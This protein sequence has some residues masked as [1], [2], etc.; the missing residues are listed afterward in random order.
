MPN[1]FNHIY[2]EISEGNLGFANALLNHL[3][4]KLPI[5]R[6]QRDLTDSTVLRN[7][8]VGFGHSLIAYQ[9]TVKGI[10]KLKVNEESLAKE[11]DG[12]WE[13]LAEPIQTVMRRFGIEKPYEKLKELTRG[14]RVNGES[15]RDFI[16]T[17]ELPDAAKAELCEL[18]PAKYIGRAV[19]FINELD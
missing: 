4:Q 8:G 10:S 15:M 6:W 5:S 1:K 18:T 13:V 11:L 17:L 19:E 9:A 14:K 16:M 2:F 3:S 12:N 7:L